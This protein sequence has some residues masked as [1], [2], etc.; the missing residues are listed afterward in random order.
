[1][2]DSQCCSEPLSYARSI[3]LKILFI[4]EQKDYVPALLGM[5]TA[6]TMLKQTPRARNQLK[7]VTKIPWNSEVSSF[8]MKYAVLF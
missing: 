2:Y 8:H 1:M 4:F 7:R 5:A 3:H 6:Y